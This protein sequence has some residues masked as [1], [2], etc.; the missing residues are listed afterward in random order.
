MSERHHLFAKVPQF[1]YSK[2]NQGHHMQ[3]CIHLV[4]LHYTKSFKLSDKK[5][6]NGA[7]QVFYYSVWTSA[8]DFCPIIVKFFVR[9]IWKWIILL[10]LEVVDIAS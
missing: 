10:K 4:L 1:H 9:Q 3:F 8:F 6:K 5:L 2:N 7:L